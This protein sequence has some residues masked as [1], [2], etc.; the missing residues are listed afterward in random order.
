MGGKG[1]PRRGGGQGSGGMGV[2]LLQGLV[3]VLLLLLLLGPGCCC[4]QRVL[5]LPYTMMLASTSAS[6]APTLLPPC[7]LPS[8]T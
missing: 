2:Y 4:C 6:L 5:I 3:A 1:T 7:F 8:P